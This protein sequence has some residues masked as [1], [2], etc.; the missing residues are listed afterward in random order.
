MK[1]KEFNVLALISALGNLDDNKERS[2]YFNLY[3]DYLKDYIMIFTDDRSGFDYT[4]NLNKITDLDYNINSLFASNKLSIENGKTY[5]TKKGVVDAT[6]KYVLINFDLNI[7]SQF[8]YVIEN[9]KQD[10]ELSELIKLCK[11]GTCTFDATNFIFENFMKNEEKKLDNESIN[12]LK[13]FEILFP[14]VDPGTNKTIDIEQRMSLLLNEINTDGF[15][16]LT[17]NLYNEIYLRELVYILAIV[18]VYFKYNKLSPKHKLDKFCEFCSRDIKAFHPS[19]C[20]L[21]KL[22][23]NNPDLKFF[24][25]IQKNNK[26]IIK[27]IENMAWDLFHLDF[28]EKTIRYNNNDSIVIPIFIS[29]DKG[30]NEI[31]KAFQLKCLFKNK[32]NGTCIGFNQMTILN[33]EYEKKY[34]NTKAVKKRLKSKINIVK[35]VNKLKSMIEE[36]IK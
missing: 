8:K 30:L 6:V 24:R 26:Q 22:F 29:K 16:K 5:K 32:I 17:Q 10:T 19:A 14:Y 15:K 34:F 35:I 18:Y 2:M 20:N 3:Y 12:D 31:R 36:L 4:A 13:V 33:E 23:Y 1:N 25:K 27:S 28:L 7:I 21:A 11:S 9:K